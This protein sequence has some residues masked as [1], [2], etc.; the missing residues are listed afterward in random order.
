MPTYE[1]VES[2]ISDTARECGLGMVP[3]AFASTDPNV[4]R[5]LGLLKSIGRR[6]LK[7]YTFLE[8]TKTHTFVTTTES[9]YALPTDFARMINQTGWN[10]TSRFPLRPSSAQMWQRLNASQAGRVSS[11]IFRPRVSVFEIWPQPPSPGETIAFE[12]KSL[13]WVKSSAAAA[14]DKTAPSAVG[15]VVCIDWTLI[16]A[17]LKY[18]YLGD[19]GYPT[20]AAGEQFKEALESVLSE[21]RIA[22]PVLNLGGAQGDAEP[23]VSSSNASGAV[24]ES[25]EILDG[26]GLF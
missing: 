12:Y 14:A 25:G 2:V 15:D 19:K 21:N 18:G 10:R 11:V 24:G 7:R 13:N 1:T 9:T 26:G 17:A 5:L 3:N 20:F 8:N 4:I 6:L 16:V 22:S 23:L